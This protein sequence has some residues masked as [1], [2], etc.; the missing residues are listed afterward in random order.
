[1]QGNFR[2]SRRI[3]SLIVGI[4]AISVVGCFI[5]VVRLAWPH[6]SRT[7][8]N[9]LAAHDPRWSPTGAYVV[10]QCAFDISNWEYYDY[11][12]CITKP[13]LSGLIRLK[14]HISTNFSL[15]PSWSPSGDMIAFSSPEGLA[16]AEVPSGDVRII[17]PECGSPTWSPNGRQMACSMEGKIMLIDVT[18]MKSKALTTSSGDINPIW[19]KDGQTI[20]FVRSADMH[21]YA[22]YQ[23]DLTSNTEQLVMDGIGSF[24]LSPND[25][26]V[27]YPK[28]KP[29]ALGVLQF[30]PHIS[31]S[32]LDTY[33]TCLAD[34]S[35]LQWSHDGQH[36]AFIATIKDSFQGQ[37]FIADLA[38]KKLFQLTKFQS[39]PADKIG[40]PSWSSDDSLIATSVD[41]LKDQQGPHVVLVP[42]APVLQSPMECR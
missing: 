38:T 23:I 25:L 42:V 2:I 39:A 1:M 18:T 32:S 17:A 36:L 31:E 33:N 9:A 16:I 28:Y 30:R 21:N 10:S 12:L 11:E 20:L 26:Y 35:H 5:L 13:D 40:S 41:E 19:T 7:L 4:F 24:A 8:S 29:T 37:I 15:D 14:K 6:S 27:A 3:L 34:I 22:L